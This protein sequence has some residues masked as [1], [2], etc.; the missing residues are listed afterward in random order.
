MQT[1]E[2]KPLLLAKKVS[3]TGTM[4]SR[5]LSRKKKIGRNLNSLSGESRS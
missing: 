1:A 3:Q 2:K 5:S 4:N